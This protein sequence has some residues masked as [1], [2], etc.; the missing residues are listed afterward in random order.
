MFRGSL[1]TW[2]FILQLTSWLLTKSFGGTFVCRFHNLNSRRALPRS[3]TVMEYLR[4]YLAVCASKWSLSEGLGCTGCMSTRSTPCGE[5]CSR[6]RTFIWLS[7]SLHSIFLSFY[8]ALS[9]FLARC[10]HH[11]WAPITLPNRILDSGAHSWR[12][13]IVW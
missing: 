3:R 9:S 1:P 12:Y 10:L 4:D 2:I 11:F 5:C 6:L 7:Q 13:H 8:L